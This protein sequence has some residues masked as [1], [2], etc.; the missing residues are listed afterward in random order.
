[1]ECFSVMSDEIEGR[2]DSFYYRSEFYELVK[3]LDSLKWKIVKLS[4]IFEINRGG[5][6]RPIHKYFTNEEN[7]INWIKIGDTK[8]VDKYIYKTNQKIKPEG[9][10]FSREVKEGDF[11]L[12]NSMSFGR[13]YIMKIKGCIHDG[14]LLLK[15][16]DKNLNKDFLYYLLSTNFIFRFFKRATLGGVVE[17]LNIDL[18][19]EIRV[20]IPPLEIQNKI[21]QLM[22]KSYSSKKQKETEAQ[23]LLDSINN[24]VLD[25]LG[26]KLPELKDK[27]TYCITSEEVK[28]NRIDAYYYQ[29]KFEEI[30]EAVKKGKFEVKELKESFENKLIKGLLP[31]KEDKNGELKVLQIKNILM[32]GL[33][34]TS[35]C[36]T[37]KNIFKEEHKLNFED[38]LIVITG[39][40]IGKIG[41]WN[42]KEDF[43]LGGDIVKFKVNKK[44]N[45]YFVQSYLLSQLGQYQ[46]IRGITG[47]TN[48]HLSP[49]DIEKIKIPLSPLA[50]QNKIA[51][52]VK[53]R[54]QKA[55]Q[56]QKDS[57][58]ELEKAKQEVEK[59][60]LN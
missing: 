8:G 43:Y 10:K 14:W 32:N 15:E 20:P 26:V 13:P 28:D 38:I 58:E 52:E 41:L 60:I 24:Y 49:S 39:A 36:I 37:S 17:N 56:L 48:G 7:G 27:M 2:L 40:T 57:K 29:P 50:I 53:Q 59:I 51:D 18:V 54:M 6:P 5:S 55:E 23:K 3:Q 22:D 30:E 4:D 46:I 42:K 35:K 25:E 33:I 19:K 44:F 45:P 31:K 12:S 16:K 34:N 9:I 47:A 11:I 1:M 21:V